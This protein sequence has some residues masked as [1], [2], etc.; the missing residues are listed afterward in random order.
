M[1]EAPK[2][3]TPVRLHLRDGSDFVGQYSDR[4]WGWIALLDPRPLIRGDIRLTGWQPASEEVRQLRRHL[5]GRVPSAAVVA[6]EPAPPT[7][8]REG[9]PAQAAA[10]M[11]GSI[12]LGGRR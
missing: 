5:R 7:G 12:S 1:S 3:G 9:P 8:D 11:S 10:L 6:T 4:W 2:D